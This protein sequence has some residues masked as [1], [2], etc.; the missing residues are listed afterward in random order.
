MEKKDFKV[1]IISHTSFST[2][3]SMGSTLL[4]YFN[5]FKQSIINQFYIKEMTPNVF[6]DANYFRQTDKLVSLPE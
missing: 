4:S 3:D 6:S 5:S 2:T 1:L